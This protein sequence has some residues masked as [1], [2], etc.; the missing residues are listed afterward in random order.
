MR[1]AQVAPLYE[2]VPPRFYGGTERIVSY[3]T[4]EL[5]RV[6]HE[7]TLFASGDSVTAARLV[8]GCTESLRLCT[9]CTDMLAPHIGQLQMVQDRLHEFD[10]VHY[11]TDYGHF[12]LSRINRHPQL[13][14]LHGR[15][16]L[17]ELQVL[18]RLYADMPVVAI[19]DDQKRPLP[20]ARW[21]A[22]IYHGLP[23]E[24]YAYYPRQGHYLAF[25]GRISKDKGIDKAIEIAKQTGLPLKIAAKIDLDAKIDKK[26]R[27]YFEKEIAPLLDHPLL[28]FLGEI[29]EEQKNEFIGNALC[30]L[31]PIDWPE[32]F[33]LVM[34]ESLACG[35]PVIAFKR[36]SVPEVIDDGLSGFVVHDTAAAVQAVGRLHRIRRQDC[37]GQ[38]EKRFTARRMTEDYLAVY[39]QVMHQL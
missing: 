1:I 7:V 38:F 12:P 32:P 23:P 17:P 33:G 10:I 31:F 6:G 9:Y 3:L 19:S 24:L 39:R 28:D 37:R 14:T 8:P 16:D 26:E 27:S 20:F 15:L 11:H 22:T 35:T 29:S 4:E 18:Y 36:G 2:R 34:I 30:V 21:A 13:T 25:L 5:V